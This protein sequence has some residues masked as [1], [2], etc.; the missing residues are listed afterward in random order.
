MRELNDLQRRF[1]GYVPQM[2]E[3]RHS[4][5]VLCPFV[6]QPDGL[7]LLFEVRAARRHAGAR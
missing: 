7:Y 3:A 4:Y 2:L 1:D 6:E 5:A